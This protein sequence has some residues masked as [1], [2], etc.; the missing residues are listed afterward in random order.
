MQYPDRCV[1]A[2]EYRGQVYGVPE[3]SALPRQMVQGLRIGGELVGRLCIAYT[4]EHDFLDEESA[5]LGDIARR[6]NGYI[7]N[8]RLLSE[9]QARAR[10]EQTLR[11]ITTRVRS[12]TDPDAVMRALVRELGTVLGRS[13]FVRLG[14]AEELS[15]TPVTPSAR[16][17]GDR[18][19]TVGDK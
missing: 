8:Q 13:T 4:E 1:V 17:S 15:Q 6:V 7:E 14:S 3:A 5:L 18:P 16:G 9:A 11:E 19:S 2:I 12:S 10:R